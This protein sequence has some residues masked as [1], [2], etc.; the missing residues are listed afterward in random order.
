MTALSSRPTIENAVPAR[1]STALRSGA[2]WLRALAWLRLHGVEHDSFPSFVG[3][4]PLLDNQGTI[5]LGSHV[6]TRSHQ[7]RP[8]LATGPAGLLTIGDRTFVNQGAV[9]HAEL[10]VTIGRRVLIGDHTAVCDTDFHEVDPGA[11]VRTAPVVIGD[12]VWLARGVVVLPGATIGEGT[13]VAAGAVVR[14]EL[15]PWVVAAGSPARPVRD[16][17][18]RGP[19]R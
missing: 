13:V 4:A 6:A 18:T 9:L 5:R 17:T 7:V 2:G 8:S 14:G 3:S 11:G 16:I 1:R 19:R 10:S 12:D 15:P